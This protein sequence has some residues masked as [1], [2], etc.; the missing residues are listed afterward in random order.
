MNRNLLIGG[1]AIAVLAVG[2]V[3]IMMGSSGKSRPG[4]YVYETSAVDRGDVA[5]IISASGAVQPRNK[6]DV[7][8]EVSGKIIKLF[9][10]Y[11]DPVKANQVLAQIDPET[12]ETAV[13]SARA[14][15]LQSEAQVSTSKSSIE[16]SQV[17]LD[18]AKKNYDR[19]K[20]LFAEGAISQ[21]AWEQADRDYKYA[22]VQL[23]SDKSSL[24][25]AEA[26]LARARASLEEAQAKLERTK[27]RSPIDGVVLSRAVEVGQTVQSSMN[28]AKFFTIAQ[29]LSQIQIEA[30]VV[31]SDIGGID[32][33]DPVTFSVDAFPGERFNGRVVQVR[34]Q[35]TEQNNVVTYTVV[36]LA[37]NPNGKLKPGMTANVEITADRA[38]DVLRIAYDATRFQPPKEV[39]EKLNAQE[40]GASG[41]AANGQRA[42]GA[43]A[44]APTGGE[45]GQRRTGGFG[46]GGQNPMTG[47]LKD[48]GV[49]QARVEKISAELRS[50]FEK[51]RASMPQQQQGGQ[52]FGGGFG[53]P[54]GLQQQQQMQEF[55]TKMQQAQ[56]SVMRRNLSEDE[57]AEFSK[58]RAEQQALK[59]APVYALND[60]GELERKVLTIGIADGDFAEIVRGAKEGDVFVVRVKANA[61]SANKK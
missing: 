39:L 41:Q 6:V 52:P 47:V 7:G 18:V 56:E 23:D 50:E 27:I 28:V 55:R 32:D 17:A 34:Q 33:N 8:S 2:G 11:N 60:K 40:A 16:R 38:T 58:R 5:R 35:G 61:K 54:A 57:F 24:K 49:D 44:G 13:N 42:G 29:D 36:I 12:F 53:P 31:E 21:A 9:V 3:A 10:D 20:S 48:M 22:V 1:A 15:L 25:S 4:A 37:A 51:A 46:P 14:S 59:R 30:D 45:G 26:G 43:P 19:Q